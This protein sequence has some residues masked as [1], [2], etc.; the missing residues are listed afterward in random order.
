MITL[1]T[2]ERNR[3]RL[4]RD[5]SFCGNSCHGPDGIIQPWEGTFTSTR[6]GSAVRFVAG[7]A[8]IFSPPQ[9]KNTWTRVGICFR[10]LIL[11][12]ALVAVIAKTIVLRLK[13]K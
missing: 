6:D 2:Q 10:V 8:G 13:G 7:Y 11:Q 3:E 5:D 1:G 9:A 12:L 4:S